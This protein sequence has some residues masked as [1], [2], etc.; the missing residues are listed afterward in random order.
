MASFAARKPRPS[1]PSPPL[2][3]PF[4][5]KLAGL[6]SL[7]SWVSL[8]VPCRRLLFDVGVA[9]SVAVLA[10]SWQ[11]RRCSRCVDLASRAPRS[12][13]ELPA[14]ERRP[15]EVGEHSPAPWA[16]TVQSRG[17]RAHSSDA[18]VGLPHVLVFG[19]L[20]GGPFQHDAAIGQDVGVVA[21]G[22]RQLHVLFHQQ[23]RE[24]IGFEAL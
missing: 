20:T 10:S 4:G 2:H 14:A 9:G 11:I 7:W 13:T 1:R 21:D 18:Q 15:R 8:L 5:P 19:H 12:S 6:F 16:Q 24:P 17:G 3:L 23:H 22:Q